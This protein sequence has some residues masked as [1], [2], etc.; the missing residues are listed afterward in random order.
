MNKKVIHSVFEGAVAK[1][2]SNIAVETADRNINYCELNTY[3]NRLSFLL[4]T[5][6]CEKEMIVNV[7][8]PSSI[9]LIASVLA[10]FKTGGIYLPAD[11]NFSEKRL[12]EIF[13]KTYN[14]IVIVSEAWYDELLK[15]TDKLEIKIAYLIV[16][17]GR[18]E[19]SLYHQQDGELKKKK[20]LEDSSWQSNSAR[21][22][23]GEDSNYIFFTSGS[24]GEGNAIV[25][26]HV[27]LS[28]FIDWEIKEFGIDSSC[29]ISQL[30]QVTFDASLRDIFAALI[31]GGTVCIPS[32]EI[33]GNPAMLLKWLQDTAITMV[34]C[35]P[36][37]FRL[38]TKEL[39][40][41]PELKYDLS[42]I[43]YLQKI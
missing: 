13:T 20:V 15:L 1:F 18:D 42:S 28:H 23:N 43:Q 38:L 16:L 35:V 14:G 37:L 4:H 7:F 34:H 30:T 19:F 41:S 21:D 32:V 39:Q 8:I 12:S 3:A 2:P 6:G 25:G 9:G 11:I 17:H 22:V 24:T 33:K 10:I 40:L 36:S 27:G 31:S 26:A 29:R 5:I